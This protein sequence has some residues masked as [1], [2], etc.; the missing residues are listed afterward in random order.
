MIFELVE[1]GSFE[2]CADFGDFPAGQLRRLLVEVVLQIVGRD[3][4]DIEI[5]G[6]T[7][8]RPIAGEDKQTFD[9]AMVAQLIFEK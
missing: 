2:M 8:H 5:F 9:R 3:K 1:R 4:V 6:P 7:L